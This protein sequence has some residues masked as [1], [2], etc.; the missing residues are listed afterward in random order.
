MLHSINDTQRTK[1]QKITRN[2]AYKCIWLFFLFILFNF[3]PIFFGSG[4]GSASVINNIYDGT[5]ARTVYV[6]KKIYFED[7][8]PFGFTSVEI[9]KFVSFVEKTKLVSSKI[10]N[11]KNLKNGSSSNHVTRRAHLHR[12]RPTKYFFGRH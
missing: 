8:I 6:T 7:G 3:F 10:V 5:E 9:Y 1:L 2:Q 11:W 4:L 12:V